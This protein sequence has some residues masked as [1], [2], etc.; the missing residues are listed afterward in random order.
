MSTSNC[1]LAYDNYITS[2]D[3][4]TVSSLKAG[5]VS[6]ALKVGTG[7]ATISTYGNYTGTTDKEYLIE[8]DTITSGTEIG[9]A[10]FRWSCGDGWEAEG[11]VTRSTFLLLEEGVQIKWTSGTGDDFA[12][13]DKWYFLKGLNFY[14]AGK[15]IDL[16]RDTSYRSATLQ[17]PNTITIDLDTPQEVST[18]IIYDHNITATGTIT[19]KADTTSSGW[20][21]FTESITYNDDKIVHYLSSPQTFQYWRLEITDTANPDGYIEISELYLGSY[22]EPDHNFKHGYGQ[23]SKSITT[24][25]KTAY[26]IIKKRFYNIQRKLKYNFPYL[27]DT[28]IDNVETILDFI[29]DRHT[30]IIKPI[31]WNEDSS[32]PNDTLLVMLDNFSYK[33][34]FNNVNTASITLEEVLQSV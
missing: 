24:K 16:N 27:T 23:D 12:L 10:T 8:I 9:Q 6:T 31:Y 3:Q 17:S 15:M 2:E 26:G 7:S 21:D 20:D 29:T 1:R 34:V 19:L 11:V 14:N 33:V 28:E 22:Y 25:N 18:L 30:G 32:T 13:A 4:I 5:I